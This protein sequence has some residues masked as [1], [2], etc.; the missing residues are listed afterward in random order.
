VIGKFGTILH[1][2]RYEKRWN[3]LSEMEGWS[4]ISYPIKNEENRKHH[5]IKKELDIENKC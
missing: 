1:N 2:M 3:I 4:K 5:R